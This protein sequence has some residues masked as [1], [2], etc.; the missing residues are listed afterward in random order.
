M[1]PGLA[2]A[3]ATAVAAERDAESSQQS[4]DQIARLRRQAESA[5]EELKQSRRTHREDAARLKAENTELRHK[6]GDARAK[7]RGAEAVSEDAN[8][9]VVEAE[10]STVVAGAHN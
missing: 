10:R 1:D 6:L 5:A 8:R 2:A 4:T 9:R 7:I 3:A